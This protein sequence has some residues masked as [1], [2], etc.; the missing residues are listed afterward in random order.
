MWNEILNRFIAE[1]RVSG[2]FLKV[3]E[4]LSQEEVLL[5]Q[6]LIEI[7]HPSANSLRA[8]LELANEVAAR[9]GFS[10]TELLNRKQ[11]TQTLEAEGLRRKEKQRQLREILFSLRYPQFAET[12]ALLQELQKELMTKYSVLL[13]LPPE[14]EGEAISLTIRSN[15]SEQ[16]KKSAEKLKILAEDPQLLKLFSVLQGDE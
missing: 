3:L 9:D 13:S 8:L 10:L 16:I 14:L 4:N 5:V 11:I 1:R 12:K 6:R 15:S 7:L 2:T